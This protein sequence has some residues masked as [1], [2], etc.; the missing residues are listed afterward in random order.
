[1]WSAQPPPCRATGRSQDP[2]RVQLLHLERGGCYLA[3]DEHAVLL[4]VGGVRR[5]T[6][7]PLGEGH[8]G[9]I[10]P[11]KEHLVSLIVQANPEHI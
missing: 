9:A 7:P 1:M 11:L 3:A 10:G 2:N 8:L 4:V 6:G 5:L